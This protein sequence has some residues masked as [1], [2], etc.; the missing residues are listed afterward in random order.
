MSGF[1]LVHGSWH[2]ESGWARTAARLRAAGHDAIAPRLPPSDAQPLAWA[3]IDLD[4]YVDA[5][6]QVVSA[7]AD[8]VVLVGHS[9]AGAILSNVA[10]RM[11]ARIAALVYVAAFLLEDG[12]SI[13]EFGAANS[14]P[15]ARGAAAHAVPAANGSC[16]TFPPEAAR[17]V[18]YN[19]CSETL[20]AEASARLR[21]QPSKPR[22]G[23]VRV[24][25]AR[26]GTV[27]RCYF[28]TLRDQ[29]VF[30]SLQARMLERMPCERVVLFDTDHSPFLSAPVRL[31]DELLAIPQW[32]LQQRRSHT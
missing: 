14:T 6:G 32:A 27:P 3:D 22:L 20:A 29:T 11:P 17:A 13:A 1:V 5:I 9:M 2:D 28:V 30:P 7:Q 26:F 16:S 25:A 31:A 21:P 8:P 15:G 12:Q 18:F 19:T 24:S 4:T 10:E 23:R